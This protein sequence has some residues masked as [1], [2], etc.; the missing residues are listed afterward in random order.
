VDA[1]GRVALAAEAAARR[2]K[3]R[4]RALM[5]AAALAAIWLAVVGVVVVWD[6]NA[7]ERP[8]AAGPTTGQHD[9]SEAGQH[10][11]PLEAW[12]AS[13][14]IGDPPAK[15]YMQGSVV[16]DG[17]IEWSIRSGPY[18]LVL[19]RVP[20]GYLVQSDFGPDH[21]WRFGVR[22]A[23]GNVYWLGS[24]EF[25]AFAVLS[26]D[27]TR[28]AVTADSDIHLYDLERQTGVASLRESG[29]VEP[30]QLVD[31]GLIYAV[32]AGGPG[33]VR[34]WNPDRSDTPEN[35]HY[36]P[37]V[38]SDDMTRA[39]VSGSKGA[40][41]RA[42]EIAGDDVT[43]YLITTCWPQRT[44]TISP[45]GAHALTVDMN[46]VDLD[47]GQVSPFQDAPRRAPLMPHAVWED[48]QRILLRLPL[49]NT[50]SRLYG[51][52]TTIRCSVT[53]LTCERISQDDGPSIRVLDATRT[54][55]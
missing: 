35:L 11:T 43:R 52:A 54:P 38:V 26:S 25:G 31:K 19:D 8:A 29:G 47:T 21:E 7:T 17:E 41:Q 46:V 24:R 14:P 53:D 40:C 5:A 49:N 55:P 20:G 3:H 15:P 23:S 33:Q 45:D 12:V 4:W 42:A 18:S 37:S 13:L 44:Y 2:R 51:K 30:I 32:Y 16:H 34:L 28:L 22:D 1:D 27:H 6:D 39:L 50:G 10:V 48:S 9:G 36:E